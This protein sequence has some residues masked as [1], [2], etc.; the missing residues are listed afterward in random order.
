MTLTRDDTREGCIP[1]S[2]SACTAY[3]HLIIGEFRRIFHGNDRSDFWLHIS[4]FHGDID[5]VIHRPTEENDL[6]AKFLGSR[7]DEHDPVDDGGKCACDDT[8]L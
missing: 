4:E 8:S 3:C 2:L 1:F 5:I 6:S 7:D